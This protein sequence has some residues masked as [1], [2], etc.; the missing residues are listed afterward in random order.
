MKLPFMKHKGPDEHGHPTKDDYEALGKQ[1]AALYD[2]INPDRK[3]LYRTAFLSGI[4]RGVG[5]I[6]G[7]TIVI[8][9]LAWVLSL[10][11]QVPFIG[12]IFENVEQSIQQPNG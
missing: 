6:I 12:P 5:G 7:A 9:I 8:V 3:G 11:G 2:H 1:V 4:V 10:L